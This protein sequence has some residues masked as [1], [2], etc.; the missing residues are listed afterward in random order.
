M[1]VSCVKKWKNRH[2]VDLGNDRCRKLPMSIKRGLNQDFTQI[3]YLL[4]F[5]TYVCIIRNVRWGHIHNFR[6]QI[7]GHRNRNNDMQVLGF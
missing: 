5:W 6:Q 1:S 2:S 4:S 7:C 3:E